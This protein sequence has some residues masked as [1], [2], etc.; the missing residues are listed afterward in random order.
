M[1]AICASP[2]FT[3]RR[4]AA[5]LPVHITSSKNRP[6][7]A[8][9]ATACRSRFMPLLECGSLAAAMRPRASANDRM[10]PPSRTMRALA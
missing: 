3:M 2:S 6:C 4:L 5:W 8:S 10:S 9:G 7:R 1:P